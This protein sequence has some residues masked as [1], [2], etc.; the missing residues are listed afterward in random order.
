MNYVVSVNEAKGTVEVV[1]EGKYKGVAKCNKADN[2]NLQVGIEL[3]LERARVAKANA[4]KP[5]VRN[6][7]DM[8]I[9][10]LGAIIER[11]LGKGQ[12]VI[13][14][15]GRVPSA[16]QREAIHSYSGCKGGYDKGYA[17]G[18]DEGYNAALEACADDYDD[19]YEDGYADAV[20]EYDEDCDCD[21]DCGCD[22]HKVVASQGV[23]VMS[24]EGAISGTMI[25]KLIEQY[26]NSLK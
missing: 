3:A 24:G 8:S 7:E 22:C 21:E 4:E 2:Y 11:K 14:G 5:K 26:E 16:E 9:R 25:R 18:Y 6:A 13:I 19:G 12:V 20:D 1:I 10:E 23:V 17:D 15:E